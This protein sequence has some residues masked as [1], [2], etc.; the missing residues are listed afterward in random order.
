M[1]STLSH[2][3]K[4]RT[5]RTSGQFTLV[6]SPS[7][8]VLTESKATVIKEK[9]S[10]TFRQSI[11]KRK[12]GKVMF[13]KG[14]TS[15]VVHNPCSIHIEQIVNHKNCKVNIHFVEIKLIGIE[16]VHSHHPR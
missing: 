11:L 1:L 12:D 15:I 9:G 3:N 5:W 7:I 13:L 4:K 2:T 8:Y 10:Q 6:T 16:T 14:K